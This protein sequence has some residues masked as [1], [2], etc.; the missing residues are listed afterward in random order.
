[1]PPLKLKNH[2]SLS[3]LKQRLLAETDIRIFKQWQILNAV[4]NNPGTKADVIASLL[5]TTPT[6]VG[7]YV[8][9]YNK[10]GPEYLSQL[11]WGGRREA[12]SNLSFA[13]EEELLKTI[14]EKSL[15][16]EI[17]TAKDIREEVEKKVK[18][19]VSEDYLWDLFKR[20][21]WKKKAPRPKHPLQDI[22]AQ[23]L[24]KKNS[25]MFWQPT[26]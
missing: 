5:G 2:L 9:L 14:A 16:G 25:P 1:M 6:I 26:L 23:D 10:H 3:E 15:K 12:R 8:R 24:F 20:H 11:K 22:S 19:S 21:G 13:E 18:R 4:S 7:R 17:L